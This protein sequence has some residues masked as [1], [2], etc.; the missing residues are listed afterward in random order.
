MM[1]LISF[2][3]VVLFAW[4]VSART[5]AQ[6]L[7]T[8]SDEEKNAGFVLLFDGKSLDG[9]EGDPNIWSVNDGVIVGQTE[10]EGPRKI[11][12]NTFLTYKKKE[13]GNFILRF[14]IKVSEAGNSGM[15]YR[16]WMIPGEQP[17][18]VAGYQADFDGK[19]GYSGILYGEGFDGILCNRGEETFLDDKHKPHTVRRFAESEALKKELRF[20]D[21]NAYEV[22][23]EGFTFTNKINGHLMSVCTDKDEVK[24]KAKGLL[25]IQAHT[26]PPMKVE[27]RNVRIKE[28]P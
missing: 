27:V 13:F 1:R 11:N 2:T 3:L 26:G 22:T 14:D 16:S 6:N 17:Y 7:P 25:A 21:W 18:R 15:Q 19:H 12:H 24:R 10:A 20:E 28:I 4:I 23:A 8:L 9:W 5:D